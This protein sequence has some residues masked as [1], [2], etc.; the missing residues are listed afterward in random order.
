MYPS[1]IST[2]LGGARLLPW[3]LLNSD[4]LQDATEEKGAREAFGGGGNGLAERTF[5]LKPHTNFQRTI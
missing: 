4:L 1:S 3:L 5:S 2:G